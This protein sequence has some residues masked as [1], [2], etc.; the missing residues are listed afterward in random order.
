MGNCSELLTRALARRSL[1]SVKGFRFC[2]FHV[3]KSDPNIALVS[4]P[5]GDLVPPD[6]FL[7]TTECLSVLSARFWLMEYWET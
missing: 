3:P 4:L 1:I 6:I 2:K 7:W 5:L